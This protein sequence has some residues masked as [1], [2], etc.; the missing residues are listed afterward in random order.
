MSDR[1]K[2]GSSLHDDYKP[3]LCGDWRG[4]GRCESHNAR[5]VDCC[6]REPDRDVVECPRCGKQWS[7]RCNFDEDMS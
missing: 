2:G 5:V 1:V 4:G 7:Q 3:E 6:G